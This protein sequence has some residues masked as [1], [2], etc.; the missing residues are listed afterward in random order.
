MCRHGMTPT[1]ADGPKSVKKPT[2]FLTNSPLLTHQLGR[3][4][5]QSHERVTHQGCRTRQAQIYP[6]ELC[7]AI[8]LG[9]RNRNKADAE[10]MFCLASINPVNNGEPN[11]AIE[12][13]TGIRNGENW[14]EAWGG[15]SGKRLVPHMARQA[16]KEEFEYLKYMSVCAK[17]PI[18]ECWQKQGNSRLMSGE[19]TSITKTMSIPSIDPGWLRK[20]ST[21]H[22]N[23]NYTQQHRP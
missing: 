22:Q 23:Q 2:G 17:V 15:V 20:R 9:L 13:S 5:D 16:G 7:R 19:S 21:D 3:N 6:D 10:G 11:E 8:C 14:W 4:C 1:T 18:E 12:K